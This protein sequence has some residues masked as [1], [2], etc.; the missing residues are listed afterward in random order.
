MIVGFIGVG[1][2]ASYLVEGLRRASPAPAIV[3]SPRN[4]ER[5]RALAARHG[6]RIAADNQGVVD[7][8]DVVILATLPQ[9]CAEVVQALRFRP[10]QRLVNM[11]AGVPLVDIKDA[12]Q[13]ALAVRAMTSS[14]A[15]LRDSP[16]FLYPDDSV[17]RDVLARFGPVHVMRDERALEVASALFI[18]Y[19]WMFRLMDEV[20]DWARENGLERSLAR[21]LVAD[22]VAAASTVARERSDETLAAILDRHTA[23]G[24]LTAHG[25]DL[26][27]RAGAFGAWRRALDAVL[28]RALGT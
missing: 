3:L 26:L 28:K 11:A 24:G 22:T 8:A 13:P 14:A 1:S 21:R 15:A 23:P 7:S 17:A 2:F 20:V 12:A 25:L 10:G 5:A 19:A 18:Y 6:A 16:G 9:Q 4:A 27:G